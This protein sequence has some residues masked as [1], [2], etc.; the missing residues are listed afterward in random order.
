LRSLVR[1]LPKPIVRALIAK[2]PPLVSWVYSGSRFADP[3]DGR[4]YRR[5]LPYGH[6][7]R[8]ENALC[9]G[10]LSLERHRLLWL[11][12]Q[13]ETRFFSDRLRVLHVA[14]EACFFPRFRELPNLDYVAGDLNSP[15]ADVY[16]DLEHLPFPDSDF[17]VILCSHVLE[18]VADDQ[19]CMRELRRVLRP[20]G[21]MLLSVPLDPK[22]ATTLEDP[23]VTDP[24]A[25]ERLYGQSDHLRLYGADYA[26]RVRELGFDVKAIEYAR[27]LSEEERERYRLVL[28]DTIFYA[29]RT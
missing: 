17:D 14:P 26:D 5:F 13:R 1:R 7:V 6:S 16:F 20:G 27:T 4:S 29:T 19:S 2:G 15:L 3:I 28:D 8:R 18:H 25:R 11:Y 22:L 12:L 10:T 24:K 9:P 23:T 21:F